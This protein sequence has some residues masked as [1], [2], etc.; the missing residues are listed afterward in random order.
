MG[1]VERR[2][3]RTIR[4]PVEILIGAGHLDRLGSRLKRLAIGTHPVILSNSTVL[5]R[6]GARTE[7]SLRRA[8]FPVRRIVVLDSERSKSEAGLRRVLQELA[9][10]DA[11]GRRLFLLLL[12]GGVIGD[13]GGLAAGLY[14]RGVPYVQVPTTLLAQADSSIGGKTAIDLPEGKNLVGLIY[15]PRLVFME[16]EFLKTLSDR[17]FRSGLAEIA[18]CGVIRDPVLFRL[19]ERHPF[20]AFREDPAL[21]GR[22]LSRA[23]RVKCAVVEQ[24]EFE[25]RGLRTVLNFGHTLGHAL[26]AA[27]GYSRAVPHGEAVAVGMRAASDIAVRLRLLRLAERDRIVALLRHLGLPTQIRIGDLSGVFRAMQ[28]DKKWAKRKNRWVLPTGIGRAT[29]R[30]GVPEPVVRAA[31]RAAARS[32]LRG[33]G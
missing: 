16:T 13:L 2:L 29:V 3:L 17:A 5:R 7:A 9:R 12:G 10:A 25:T 20:G 19:L 31:V 22:A 32:G 23:V 1:D 18:K 26:E 33:G 11:P 15:Q 6:H 8:G 28:R 4:W 24:D 27:S 21:L 14:R 30:E